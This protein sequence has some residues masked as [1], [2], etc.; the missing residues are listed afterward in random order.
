MAVASQAETYERL[1]NILP[2][3]QISVAPIVVDERIVDLSPGNMPWSRDDFDVGYVFPRRV[4]EGDVASIALDIPWIND[5]DAILRSRNKA[6]T[7]TKLA[8]GGLPVPQ[9][10]LI[11]NPVDEDD[12]EAAFSTFNGPVIIKPN[13]TT[14]GVG[15]ARADD[16]DTFI[17]IADYLELVHDFRA[18]GDKSYLVQEFIE[19]ARDLR[20]MVIDGEYAGAVERIRAGDRAGRW[21]LNVHRGAHARRVT[22]DATCRDLAEAAA[23]ELDI[24]LLG[25]DLLV[26][27]DGPV[28]SETNAR[29]TID[30]P[31]KYAPNFIDQFVDLIKETA[32]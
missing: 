9:T 4:L 11:S 30:D 17:G 23:A 31:S 14:R 5:R 24:P 29:P 28:I 8:N 16:V 15:V 27:E 10:L 18:T 2:Q 3:Y 20:V 26:T 12:L 25:I 1:S 7:L 19:S 6:A 22:P 32:P 13:T 21:K